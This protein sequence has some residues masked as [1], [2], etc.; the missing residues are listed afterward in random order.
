MSF[1]TIDSVKWWLRWLFRV[2]L[3]GGGSQDVGHTALKPGEFLGNQ[4]EL[5][6]L[7]N[8]ARISMLLVASYRKSQ[9]NRLK[10]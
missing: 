9:I 8:F 6:T 5:A 10:L 3:D 4:D 7:D 1:A 2:V